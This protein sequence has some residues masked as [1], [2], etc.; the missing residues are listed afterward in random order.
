[1]RAGLAGGVDFLTKPYEPRELLARVRTH[2]A[3]RQ[4]R[5]ELEAQNKRLREEIEAHGR[6]RAIL[7][8]LEDEIRTGHGLKEIIG[9]SPNLARLL[10]Q[11]ALVAAT[12]STVLVARRDGHGQGAR[13]ARDPRT[14]SPR[15]SGRS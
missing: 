6:S 10:D 5:R 3:L 13:R 8:C 4:A 9:R 11:L 2:V 15:A 7:H 1:M 12:D 14:G